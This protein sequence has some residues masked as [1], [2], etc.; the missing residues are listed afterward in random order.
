MLQSLASVAFGQRSR[1]ASPRLSLPIARRNFVIRV[2]IL[3]CVDELLRGERRPVAQTPPPRI[4]SR[5][6]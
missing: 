6:L 3:G 2:D 5:C 1:D 4:A